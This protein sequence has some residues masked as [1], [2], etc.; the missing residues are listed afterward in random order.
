MSL[1]ST[2]AAI[3]ADWNAVRAF[4]ATHQTITLVAVGVALWLF[5]HFRW[6]I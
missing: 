1:Q 5:G 3:K 4:I 2:E 6:P